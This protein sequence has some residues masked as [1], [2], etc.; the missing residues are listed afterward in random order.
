MKR[1]LV[2]FVVFLLVP[3]VAIKVGY[4]QEREPDMRKTHPGSSFPNYAWDVGDRNLLTLKLLH[5]GRYQDAFKNAE[6]TTIDIEK[7]LVGQVYDDSILLSMSRECLGYSLVGLG[8]YQEAEEDFKALIKIREPMFRSVLR[9]WTRHSVRNSQSKYLSLISEEELGLSYIAAARGRFD[10]SRKLF[11][12][13][14]FLI[15][16]DV[17]YPH[18][19]YPKER[20][21]AQLLLGLSGVKVVLGDL[22][23][24]DDD[25]KYAREIQESI[26]DSTEAR[27][28]GSTYLAVGHLRASEGRG[29]EAEENFNHAMKLFQSL[30]Y[31]HPNI[32]F[33]LDG[34]ADL[35]LA[36]RDREHAE[37]LFKQS[38]ELREFA[39]GK[40]FRDV[41]YSLDGLGRAKLA[42]GYPFSAEK[43]FA[44]ALSILSKTLGDAHPDTIQI[45]GHELKAL[46]KLDRRREEDVLKRRFPS[47]PSKDSPRFLTN[48]LISFFTER[49]PT[50]K[51]PKLDPKPV[52]REKTEGK[53]AQ[54]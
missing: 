22:S 9:E 2:P 4:S 41:A 24:A 5:E 39:L 15:E 49:I 51:P 46:A 52:L 53:R 34:L 35:L 18:S 33:C 40:D 28:L 29:D 36:K 38:L 26:Y 13:T 44:R 32:G 10:E 43:H 6:T 45:A 42:Q 12:R 27:V 54:R 23:G 20:E 47:I 21:K 50:K 8:R 30:S 16:N 1:F 48:P 25:L 7:N 3:F 17:G 11:E 31:G 37:G 14:L 19:I